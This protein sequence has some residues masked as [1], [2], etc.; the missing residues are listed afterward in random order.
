M[1]VNI[2]E[3]YSERGSSVSIYNHNI[4]HSFVQAFWRNPEHLSEVLRKNQRLTELVLSF[5]SPEGKTMELLCNGLSNPDFT[6]KKL[7]HPV[8]VNILEIYSERGSFI[9][10]YNHILFEIEKVRPVPQEP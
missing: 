8:K 9:S 7:S 1:K 5:K 4:P 2:L 10:I 3:I 6:I